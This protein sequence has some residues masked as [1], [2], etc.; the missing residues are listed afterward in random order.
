MSMQWDRQTSLLRRSDI[1]A[2]IASK[3]DMYSRKER[4]DYLQLGLDHKSI[5]QLRQA[6]AKRLANY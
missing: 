4:L 5:L 1:K 2:A 3:L 6:Y